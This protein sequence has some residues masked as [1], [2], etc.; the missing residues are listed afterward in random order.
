MR[1][2]IRHHR[3][4]SYRPPVNNIVQNGSHDLQEK[5]VSEMQA[6]VSQPSLDVHPG[7]PQLSLAMWGASV[8][9]A[10]VVGDDLNK[11]RRE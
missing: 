5:D 9:K 6:S 7:P 1:G 8:T 2:E 10:Q 4:I 3:R 11:A